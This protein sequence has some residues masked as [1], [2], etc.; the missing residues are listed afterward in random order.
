VVARLRA[1][2]KRVQHDD[3]GMWLI[4]NRLSL[5]AGDG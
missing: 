4:A 3:G 2:L 5:I 1:M